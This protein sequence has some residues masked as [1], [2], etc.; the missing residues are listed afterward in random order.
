MSTK[1]LSKQ[2]QLLV[3][4][5][6]SIVTMCTFPAC[7]RGGAASQTKIIPRRELPQVIQEALSGDIRAAER[8]ASHY[9]IGRADSYN[10]IEWFTVAAENGH[11]ESTYGLIIHLFHDLN[12]IDFRK[13]GIFWLYS[14]AKK[15]YRDT[16]AWLNEEGHTLET[17]QPPDDNFF[18]HDYIEF[19]D[20]MLNHYKD[21]ALRGNARAA[22]ILGRYFGE[23]KN[24]ITSSEYWFRIGA[25]NG[26]SESK[27]I[28]GQILIAKNDRNAKIRGEFWLMQAA[29]L[30]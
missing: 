25:Q 26:C 3:F 8:L 22:F 20:S 21:G 27:R 4:L 14:L 18:P 2:L 29:E 1:K 30:L 10:A 7:L 5:I 11:L 28:L 16:M 24:D 13:R 15:D 12:N 19:S 6:V 17:A 23:V 9:A